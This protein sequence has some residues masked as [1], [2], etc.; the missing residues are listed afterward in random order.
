MHEINHHEP[1]KPGHFRIFRLIILAATGLLSIVILNAPISLRANI[2]PQNIGEVAAQDIQ[3]PKA[4]TYESKVLTDQ[5]KQIARLGVS[6]VYLPSDPSIKRQQLDKLRANLLFI[7]QVK[8]DPYA[9][10][11]QKLNDL[12]NIENL[13]LSSTTIQKILDLAENRWQDIQS[14]SI[15]ILEVVFR[16]TIRETN[17]SSIRND[18]PSLV[19]ASFLQSSASIVSE[20]TSQFVIPN[21]KFSQELTDKARTE[22]ESK[23]EPVTRKY[24]IGQ[25][26]IRHGQVIRAEDLEA[27]Q[28][29]GLTDSTFS[30]NNVL[31][32]SALVVVLMVFVG[33][34]GARRQT[35][36]LNNL[37]SLILISFT[38]IFFL[39]LGRFVIP[40]RTVIPFIFP[41]AAFGLTLATAFT[42]E[43]GLV[44]SLVLSI[45]LGYGLP[46]SLEITIFYTIG[47]LCGI[48]V[49]GRG[50]NIAAFF[51]ASIAMSAVNSLIILAYRLSD[52]ITDW[53]GLA[54]LIGASFTN[55]LA[56]ASL[57]L[58]LQFVYAQTLGITTA[59]Q[60][61][62]LSRP[63][64]PLLQFMLRNTPGTYQHSL[65]VANLAEQAAE[66]INADSLLVRVGAIY[67]D[68]GKSLNPQFF[69]ENQI[70]GD[71][72]PH[73]ELD[74]LTSAEVIIRH[75]QDGVSLAKKYK[76]PPRI[77]DFM[78]EHH[79]NLIT[80][81]QYHRA[82][83][84]NGD[85]ESKVD[86]E[87]Y[88]YPG[89]APRSR[90]TAILMLADGSEARARAELPKDETELRATIKKVID[91]CLIE[92]Q[93]DN[94]NLTLNDLVKI[95]DSFTSTLMGVYHQR[96]KYPELKKPGEPTQVEE[97]EQTSQTIND[98][99]AN[100][101]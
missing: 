35:S 45:L 77:Q 3:S 30:L 70:K 34:Y 83:S 39:T 21:S 24:E 84:E 37:R 5:A 44:F 18:I 62:D 42:L 22:A 80:R 40:Y 90:E 9:T 20:I 91:K 1:R 2:I 59:I 53:V 55:G 11:E 93:L 41:A 8:Q 57:T 16:S 81:Y 52:P 15:K 99:A 47:S 69:I 6:P 7:T 76:L 66:A 68:A 101:N 26:I 72:N 64:H 25:N 74:V 71:L 89:P 78:R 82:V 61:L 51:R 48:L 88:R 12:S 46:G 94:S 86:M 38:F 33:L 92:G 29:I 32:S 10:P 50:R 85:D 36:P 14:E 67:H 56:S 87:A 28:T 54:T 49:L 95:T 31:S 58:I 65:Q 43:I 75:V 27:L 19:D 96:I 60:L 100:T 63:D 13:K 79:G 4:I 17:L 98:D 73:D 97:I 23:I